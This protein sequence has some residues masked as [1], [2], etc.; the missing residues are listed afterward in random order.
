MAVG[1][2]S[3]SSLHYEAIAS[4]VFAAVVAPLLVYYGKKV[5]D[6]LDRPD[7]KPD[8]A[9]KVSGVWH[10]DGLDAGDA[11]FNF[12][13]RIEMAVKHNKVRA[14]AE[15]N[16]TVKDA[17]PVV[18]LT[19][20][21]LLYE[22]RF[23]ELTYANVDDKRKQLGIAMFELS[24]GELEFAGFFAGY[25][26]QRHKLVNGSLNINKLDKAGREAARVAFPK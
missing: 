10:G 11:K 22:N 17:A 5:I 18:T 12:H 2:L 14:K 7:I 25:S 26:P 16:P 20:S 23:L 9:K 15:L 6:R 19:M 24:D 3:W 8:I 1:Y 21:G 13:A 4:S